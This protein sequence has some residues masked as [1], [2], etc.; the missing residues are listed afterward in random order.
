MI[1]SVCVIHEFFL[2]RAFLDSASDLQISPTKGDTC[3]R[4]DWPFNVALA[5][6]QSPKHAAI[7]LDGEL[8]I[9][10]LN[11]L[12]W[13]F[14]SDSYIVCWHIFCSSVFTQRTK[15]IGP[16]CTEALSEAGKARS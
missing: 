1:H 13:H 8:N 11:A 9:F 2:M 3:A 14:D 12:V 6:K 5:D 16:A 7:R 15:L 10:G 4:C